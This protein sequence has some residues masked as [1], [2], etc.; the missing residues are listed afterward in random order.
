MKIIFFHTPFNN[1]QF[2]LTTENI[3][4]LSSI[5]TRALAFTA[6]W[7]LDSRSSS[8]PTSGYVWTNK[9]MSVIISV[10]LMTNLN[11]EIISTYTIGLAQPLPPGRHPTRRL[12]GKRLGNYHGYFPVN[13]KIPAPCLRW[14]VSFRLRTFC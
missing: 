9:S 11:F 8:T 6:E 3:S 1:K 10:F 2:K 12:S 14:A 13:W 5:Y 4:A 7:R